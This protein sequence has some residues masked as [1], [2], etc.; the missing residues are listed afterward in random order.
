MFK[1]LPMLQLFVLSGCAPHFYEAKALKVNIE[2]IKVIASGEL[3]DNCMGSFEIPLIYEL[4]RE[5]Y[6]IEFSVSALQLGMRFIQPEVDGYAFSSPRLKVNEP[7]VTGLNAGYT[8]YISTLE[9]RDITI[10]I[11]EQE[12][13]IGSEVL[14]ISVEGCKAVLIDAI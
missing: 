3:N 12:K 8:H 1:L 4:R 10:L 6:T 11:L 9:P 13:E 5:L 7:Y 2:G 14:S